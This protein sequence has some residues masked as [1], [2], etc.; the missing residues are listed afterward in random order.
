[1]YN[2]NMPSKFHNIQDENKIKVCIYQKQVLTNS[3]IYFNY[4]LKGFETKYV[5]SFTLFFR[6]LIIIY[7]VGLGVIRT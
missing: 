5:P 7:N 1:M 2:L 4:S 3:N 6:S